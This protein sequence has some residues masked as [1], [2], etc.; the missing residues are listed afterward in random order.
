MLSRKYLNVIF[1]RKQ[2]GEVQLE[3]KDMLETYEEFKEFA[4]AFRAVREIVLVSGKQH[5]LLEDIFTTF[6][7]V[8]GGLGK[9]VPPIDFVTKRMKAKIAKLDKLIAQGTEGYNR[10]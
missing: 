5:N 2:Y 6:R 3:D 10:W 9:G 8:R 1:T 7:E 4:T